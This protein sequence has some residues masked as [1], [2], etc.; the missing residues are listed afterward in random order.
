MCRYS[1]K[2]NAKSPTLC[3]LPLVVDD[4]ALLKMVFNSSN[5]SWLFPTFSRNNFHNSPL[6]GR[7]LILVVVPASGFSSLESSKSEELSVGG[8]EQPP[9]TMQCRSVRTKSSLNEVELGYLHSSP[10]DPI[11]LSGNCGQ[12]PPQVRTIGSNRSMS[13]DDPDYT[14]EGITLGD[15]SDRP[16][17]AGENKDDPL[18]N[19]LNQNLRP[20]NPSFDDYVL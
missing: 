19:I 3:R 1:H 13:E 18:R 5:S 12:Q 14:G 15:A 10:S 7:C 4:S 6:T 17:F 2:P 20:K 9:R 11:R 8:D 16:N